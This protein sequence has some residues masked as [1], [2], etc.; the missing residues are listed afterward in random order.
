MATPSGIVRPT[1]GL[2]RFPVKSMRGEQL[3]EAEVT[4]VL[5]V[6]VVMR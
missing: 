5:W 6:T 2:W 4:E 3:E 1:A